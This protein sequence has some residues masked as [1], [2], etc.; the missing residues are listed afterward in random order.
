MGMFLGNDR[1][2]IDRRKDAGKTRIVRGLVKLNVETIS[3]FCFV[4]C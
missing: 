3:A 4:V 2:D 1:T